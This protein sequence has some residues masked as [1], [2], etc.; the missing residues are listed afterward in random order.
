MAWSSAD[1]S[2]LFII[3]YRA[4]SKYRRDALRDWAFENESLLSTISPVVLSMG[5]LP[6]SHEY[7]APEAFP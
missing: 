2:L 1:S 5:S 4:S 3:Q 7:I 6:M